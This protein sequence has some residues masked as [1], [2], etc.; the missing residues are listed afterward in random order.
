MEALKSSQLHP[1]HFLQNE[2]LEKKKATP[3]E[4][5]EK[6]KDK[7]SSNNPGTLLLERENR[8]NTFLTVVRDINMWQNRKPD[9]C[10]SFPCGKQNKTSK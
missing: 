10:R 8:Q 6:K 1:S 2:N 9:L 5:K 3:T 7:S 4:P